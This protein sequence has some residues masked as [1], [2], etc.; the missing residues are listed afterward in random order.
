MKLR[1][2]L[3]LLLFSLSSLSACTVM[4][5]KT[6]A[7]YGK[8]VF[9][10]QNALSTEIMMIDGEMLLSEDDMDE[11]LDEEA[12]MQKACRL[13]ND[14]ALKKINKESISLLFKKRA[15]DSIEDCADSIGNVESLL[16]DLEIDDE[17]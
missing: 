15:N 11:L 9:K 10:R 2:R 4:S 7:D 6:R 14:Y 13:L 8:S 17:Y 1:Y 5:Y 12:E 16:E 3:F